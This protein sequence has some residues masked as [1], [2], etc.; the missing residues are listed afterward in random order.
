MNTSAYLRLDQWIDAHFDEQ[1]SF[2]Q[3]V[4]SVPTDTPPGNNT[5]HA[6]HTAQLLKKYDM[7]A[8]AHAVPEEVVHAA[9]LESITN[10]IVKR[11]YGQGGRVLALNAHG[12]GEAD[13][14]QGDDGKK[15]QHDDQGHSPFCMYS[16][17]HKT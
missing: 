11:Q 15:A 6:L 4:L 2:L 8:E 13:S 17:E 12:D 10:L 3:S 7:Q 14:H 1:V 9:G 5:P 16:S